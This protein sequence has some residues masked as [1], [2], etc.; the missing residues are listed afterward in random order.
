VIDEA[1]LDWD[2]LDDDEYFRPYEIE[3]ENMKRID[4]IP[5]GDEEC[6]NNQDMRISI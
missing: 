2:L 3:E 1:A 4:G 6:E 5:V